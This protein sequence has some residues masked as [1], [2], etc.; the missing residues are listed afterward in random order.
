MVIVLA[1]RPKVGGFKPG[2]KKYA[3]VHVGQRIAI[4]TE[5]GRVYIYDMDWITAHFSFPEDEDGDGPRNVGF[6]YF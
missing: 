4:N 6:I 3:P 1:T 5:L 2:D